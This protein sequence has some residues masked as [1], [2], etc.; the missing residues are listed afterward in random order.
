MACERWTGVENLIIPGCEEYR[1]EQ[2]CAGGDMFTSIAFASDNGE[3][4]IVA[5]NF[6]LD[7]NEPRAEWVETLPENI[8]S[9]LYM[10]ED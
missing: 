1:C 10:D 8:D 4:A 9:I 5:E 3:V 6:H 7:G 2:G